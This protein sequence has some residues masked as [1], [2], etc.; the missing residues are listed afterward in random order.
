MMIMMLRKVLDSGF[1]GK[2]R[3]VKKRVVLVFS[4]GRY[5]RRRAG[6]CGLHLFKIEPQTA[7]VPI[8]TAGITLA[9]AM[10]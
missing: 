7:A 1:N 9:R 10:R 2:L 6:Q 8:R 4:M 5:G 3:E